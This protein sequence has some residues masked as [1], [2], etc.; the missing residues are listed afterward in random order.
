ML[1]INF[2]MRFASTGRPNLNPNIK[3][4]SG[5]GKGSEKSSPRLDTN[6]NV[7]FPPLCLRPLFAIVLVSPE[8]SGTL[9]FHS[10]SPFTHRHF[11]HSVL[12]VIRRTQSV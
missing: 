9:D 10:Q 4:V 3:S 1:T 12:E 2:A 5:I 8:A 7:L 6:E 11:V